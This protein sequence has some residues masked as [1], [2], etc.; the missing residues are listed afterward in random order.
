MLFRSIGYAITVNTIKCSVLMCVY[1]GDDAGA[2]AASLASL[3]SQS[4]PPDEIVLV[5]DGP[6]PRELANVIQSVSSS[7]PGLLTIHRLETNRGLI[8]SLNAGL[9]LCRG[10]FLFRMDADDVCR[11]DRIEKQLEFMEGHA[12]IGVLGSAMDEF[13]DDPAHPVRNKPR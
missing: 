4:R 11:T 8:A 2:L 5:E 6:L 10:E 12:Q 13:V 3:V 9:K 1:A 7:R